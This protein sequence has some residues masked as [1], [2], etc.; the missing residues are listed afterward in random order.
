MSK[1]KLPKSPYSD[2]PDQEPELN[3]DVFADELYMTAKEA[4][5][6]HTGAFTIGIFGT[7][8]SGKTTLMKAIEKRFKSEKQNIAQQSYKTI[9]FNPW[10]YDRKEV[11]WNALIQTILR[12]II[13]DVKDEKRR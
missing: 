6:E 8:G 3:F 13:K 9:W 5:A 12:D 11:I 10:K 4:V 7:W 2:Q 1:N